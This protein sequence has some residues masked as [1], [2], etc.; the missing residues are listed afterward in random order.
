MDHAVEDARRAF[1]DAP[2]TAEWG[3]VRLQDIRAGTLSPGGRVALTLFERVEADGRPHP[4]LQASLPPVEDPDDAPLL[5][6]E[7]TAPTDAAAFAAWL[8]RA[9]DA[10]RPRVV[11]HDP[12]QAPALSERYYANSLRAQRTTRFLGE[13]AAR[14][15]TWLRDGPLP[16]GA[17]DACRYALAEKADLAFATDDAIAFDDHDTGTYHSFGHDAPF[18]HYLEALLDGLPAEDSPGFDLHDG[19][20]QEA[21]RRQR[22]QAR[23][24]LDHLMRHKYAFDGVE[25]TDIEKSVGGLLIDRETRHV[26]SETPGSADSLQPRY[27]LLRVDPASDHAH[28][29][30]WVHRD[31]DTLRL[32]DGAAIEVTEADLRS[33]PVEASRLT[34]ERAPRDAR[35][36]RGVRFD[37][38]GDGYVQPDGIGWIGWAGHCDVKAIMEQLGITLQRAESVT[39][40]RSDT[41]GTTPF[42]RDLLVEM[43]ASSME[44]GSLYT[45]ADGS[46]LVRRGIQRFGGARNDSRPDRLQFQG[47]GPGR[48]FRWPLTGRQDALRVRRIVEPVPEPERGTGGETERAL[49]LDLAFFRY[50]PDLA[51]PSF[52]DNPRFLKTVEGDYNLIDVSGALL[53]IDLREDSIDEST[54]YPRHARVTTT[55]DLRAT[56]SEPRSYLG[57]HVQDAAKREIYKVWLDRTEQRIEAKLYRWERSD[58]G[59]SPVE[60]PDQAVHIPLAGPLGVTLSREMKRD[61]PAAFRALLDQGLRHAQN[62][63]ADTDMASEVWNGVVTRIHATRK[64]ANPDTRTEHWHVAITARFGSAALDY[65]VRRDA[66]G[67]PEAYCPAR[68]EE[69]FDKTPDFLWQDF[70]DVGTKGQVDGAWVV[71]QTMVERGIVEAR[72]RPAAP[73]GFYVYDEHIKNV[74]ELLYAGLSG[75]RWTI[76][77]RNKRYGFTDE[78]AWRAAVAKL[79]TLRAAVRVRTL[80]GETVPLVTPVV[81]GGEDAHDAPTEPAAR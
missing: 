33:T 62:I 6:E 31:G 7:V 55:V 65:L 46:G 71:N 9:W 59:W 17:R 21:L 20:Q 66:R 49:D 48:S 73:G 5:G 45:R 43:V 76:V 42:S 44:L 14:L 1:A 72:P 64:A 52:D 10:A 26:V 35:L 77:H 38:N 30:A 13:V 34:F 78:A 54:G 47:L 70:P 25:E 53:E 2:L 23:N 61:D 19:F 40:Y 57:T 60:V 32:R 24:H 58:A 68:G 29:G 56:P 79:E 36:R 37:W 28:A 39:E 18:V 12:G 51:G 41:G 4:R 69:S 27:V 8:D 81:D 11:A 63:C 67:E 15:D 80:S 75:H 50:R 22:Q 16:A 3:A 74:Y